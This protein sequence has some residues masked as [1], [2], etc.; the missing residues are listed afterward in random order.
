MNR[1]PILSHSSTTGGCHS[2][3]ERTDRHLNHNRVVLLLGSTFR[4]IRGGRS[5]H[6][7]IADQAGKELSPRYGGAELEPDDGPDLERASP[8]TEPLTAVR[9][10]AGEPTNNELQ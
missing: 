3:H 8:V 4:G 2:S 9:P 7:T 5:P 6:G 1:V 10:D